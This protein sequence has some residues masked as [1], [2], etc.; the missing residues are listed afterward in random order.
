M[1]NLKAFFPYVQKYRRE[2]LLGIF[3]LIVAD[4]MTLVV[5]LLIKEFIDILPQK[6]AIEP[7]LIYVLYLFLISL[8][9]VVGRYGWRKYMFG[10]SRKI[11]FD[12]LNDLFSHL[13]SLDR[14][15]YQKQKTGDLMSRATNDLRA[16][17]YTHLTLPTIYSV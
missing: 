13:L 15:W 8:V 3:S 17:S 12:I 11:E 6:P 1:N 5:P 14:L 10:L 7:L 16:V 9:L 2:F 4:C